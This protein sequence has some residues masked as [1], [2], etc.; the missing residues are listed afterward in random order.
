MK[1]WLDKNVGKG[2]WRFEFRGISVSNRNQRYIDL[3]NEQMAIM[4]ALKWG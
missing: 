1:H 2:N 3:D 4:F